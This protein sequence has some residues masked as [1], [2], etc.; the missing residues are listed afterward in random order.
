M[1]YQGN[2]LKKRKSHFSLGV[3]CICIAIFAWIIEAWGHDT[4]KIRAGTETHTLTKIWM[5]S[6]RSLHWH[7]DAMVDGAGAWDQCVAD[8]YDPDTDS[9]NLRGGRCAEESLP[10]PPPPTTPTPRPTTPR[11]PT[12]PTPSASAVIELPDPDEQPAPPDDTS[13]IDNPVEAPPLLRLSLW[14][15]SIMNGRG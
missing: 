12:N 5:D 9:Y 13:M 3:I 11:P 14:S 6:G 4:P 15:W 7:E 1:Y 2:T 10:S 8:A